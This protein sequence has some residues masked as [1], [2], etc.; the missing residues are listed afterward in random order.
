MIMASIK[1]LQ[2]YRGLSVNLDRAIDWITTKVYA[3]HQEDGR[4]EIDGDRVFAL[5]MRYETKDPSEAL[6]ETHRHHIDIQMLLEGAE[7]VEVADATGLQTAVPY[8]DDIEFQQVPDTPAHTVMLTPGNSVILFPEEAHRP[9]LSVGS[10][11]TACRKVVVK[12]R[13]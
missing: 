7:R 9:S 3:A 5:F 1:D 2:R 13:I 4:L 6:F 8:V 12:V 10:G 11:R